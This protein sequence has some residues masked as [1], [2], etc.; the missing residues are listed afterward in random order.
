MKKQGNVFVCLTVFLA[1]ATAALS[2]TA[3][4]AEKPTNEHEHALTMHAGVPAT[5]TENGTEAYWECSGCEMMFSDEAGNNAIEAA[6]VIPAS[7]G[8]LVKTDEVPATCT[9][10]GAEAYWSC[11]GCGIKFADEAGVK[12]IESPVA[13][14]ASHG[15]LVKTDEVPATC[16]KDGAE[17]YWSCVDCG[18]KFSDEAGT[19][20][21]EDAVA[22]PAIG[23]ADG[24][25]TYSHKEDT[26]V[27]I[28]KCANADCPGAE[29]SCD[30][31]VSVNRNNC[32]EAGVQTSVCKKC[33]N[34][35]TARLAAGEHAYAAPAW[36]W[37]EDEGGY[38]VTARFVCAKEDDMQTPA[39]TVTENRTN[40]T[41]DEAGSV[42]YT[43]K[44]VFGD[45]E[46]TDIKTVILP[47][48]G[49]SAT[50]HAAVSA[51]CTENGTEA[52]WDCTACGKLYADEDCTL[53]M[54]SPVVISASG[55]S[56]TA[57]AAVSA[58]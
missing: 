16:T 7:H 53:E 2:F 10:D 38:T 33:G 11:S 46:Y 8:T 25:K 57:H 3:C 15:T 23:H 54:L 45:S 14:V 43:A 26:E 1:A 17:A 47:A 35:V 19:V 32:D 22:I 52:Y 37:T 6:G 29:E 36:A 56:V 44:V 31:E 58:A 12:V 55:H 4:G 51:T 18:V 30:Y 39:A 50:A 41:C 28:W 42:V 27:H 5:C 34:V 49:H 9:K 40:A 13:I 24:E 20:V 21:I 48:A